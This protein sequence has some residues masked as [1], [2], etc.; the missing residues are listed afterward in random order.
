[1]LDG[2]VR[3][4]LPWQH[5]DAALPD[6]TLGDERIAA[7]AWEREGATTLLDDGAEQLRERLKLL[8]YVE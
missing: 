3:L 8:G 5:L 7:V 2:A 4:P 6:L 1:V